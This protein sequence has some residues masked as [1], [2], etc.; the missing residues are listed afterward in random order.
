M[1]SL[2]GID[3][4]TFGIGTL[5]GV[6]HA[7]VQPTYEVDVAHPSDA[8]GATGRSVNHSMMSA[9]VQ[10]NGSPRSFSMPAIQQARHDRPGPPTLTRLHHDYALTATPGICVGHR[11]TACCSR[12]ASMLWH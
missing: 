5:P 9:L 6:L 11:C 8:M 2:I 10:L 3:I 4:Y 1:P 12:S 7:L